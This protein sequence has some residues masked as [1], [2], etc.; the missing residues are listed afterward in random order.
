MNQ[1]IFEKLKRS[2]IFLCFIF[3]N[4]ECEFI[5][6]TNALFY[7]GLDVIL[8]QIQKRKEKVL[9]SVIVKFLVKLKEIIA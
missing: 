1:E 4:R 7:H 8:S 5:F 6:D 9:V 3:S 2:L